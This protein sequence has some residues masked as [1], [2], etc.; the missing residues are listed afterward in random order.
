ML[1]GAHTVLYSS[2][3]DATRAF[4]RDVLD[5]PAVDAG[6]GWL[7]LALPPGEVAVHPHDTPGGHELFL[8]CDDLGTTLAG[9]HAKGVR[10][11]P[12][13]EQR[14]GRLT[15]L[16]LPGGVSVGLYEPRHPTAIA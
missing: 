3:A 2:D 12:V 1:I 7:V 13:S 10:S 5:L 6:G 11:G 9:L 14:W 4:L 16:E 8:M 15:S